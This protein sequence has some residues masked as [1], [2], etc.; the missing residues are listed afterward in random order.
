MVR[1]P[2][3]ARA[4]LAPTFCARAGP[5]LLCLLFLCVRGPPGCAARALTSCALSTP[6]TCGTCPPSWM[7]GGSR[8]FLR[9]WGPTARAP[10]FLYARGQPSPQHARG[11]PPHPRSCPRGAARALPSC[12]PGYP[13]AAARV[14]LPLHAGNSGTH[15]ASPCF[16]GMWR[17]PPLIAGAG[18]PRDARCEF[19]LSARTGSA[20]TRA[21]AARAPDPSARSMERA[22]LPALM[23]PP[24]R[25]ERA[26][27]SCV[28]GRRPPHTSGAQGAAQSPG[29][30][31]V[32]VLTGSAL[33][34]HSQREPPLPGGVAHRGTSPHLLSRA[35]PPP[36]RRVSFPAHEEFPS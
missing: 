16:L 19:S 21:R 3:P 9:A 24:A 27:T 8:P 14:P 26:P 33:A 1:A 11:D 22:P 25:V 28:R 36:P 34:R 2:S 17:E 31:P 15:G 30:L 4:A 5:A 12:A 6:G 35:G 29:F 7:R 32:P 20:L 13:P 18:P 23:R 10:G